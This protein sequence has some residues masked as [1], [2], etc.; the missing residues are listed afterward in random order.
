MSRRELQGGAKG[1]RVIAGRD[2]GFKRG[3]ALSIKPNVG[4]SSLENHRPASRAVNGN[5]AKLASVHSLGH[6]DDRICREFGCQAFGSAA[7]KR[8]KMNTSEMRI[9]E[10]RRDGLYGRGKLLEWQGQELISKYCLEVEALERIVAT[11]GEIVGTKELVGRGFP[12]VVIRII[13]LMAFKVT[14]KALDKI[15]AVSAEIR[16]SIGRCHVVS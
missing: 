16:I 14:T 10:Q 9:A 1:I 13:A 8:R 7:A 6:N 2:N 4:I 15:K 5:Q 11:I 12:K 3:P